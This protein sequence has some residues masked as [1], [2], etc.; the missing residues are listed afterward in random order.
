MTA[1]TK[2]FQN[3]AETE[4]LTASKP[5]ALLVFSAHW[6]SDYP[7]VIEINKAPKHKLYYDY[8]GFPEHTY[9]LT[10]PAAGTITVA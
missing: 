8:G 7:D 10:W 1:A 5:K 3:L 9:R 4:G 2:W 6:E